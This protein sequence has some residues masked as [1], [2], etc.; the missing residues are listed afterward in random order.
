MRD[1]GIAI[2]QIGLIWFAATLSFQLK[3]LPA[4]LGMMLAGLGWLLM[5]RHEK[6]KLTPPLFLPII[7]YLLLLTGLPGVENTKKANQIIGMSVP[8][9]VFPLLFGFNQSQRLS[10]LLM[11][12][13]VYATAIS[14]IISLG[15]LAYMLLYGPVDFTY[16]HYSPFSQIPSHYIAMYFAFAGGIL[17]LN[18]PSSEFPNANALL[19]GFVLAVALL[20]NARIQFLVVAIILIWWVKVWVR[21]YPQKL[22][23]VLTIIVALVVLFF[24]FPEN[25]RRL[26]ETKDEFRNLANIDQSKQ[27]NHRFYLWEHAFEVISENPLMGVGTGDAN[28]KLR[29]AYQKSDAQFWD[30][31]GLY[32]LRDIGYNYHNQFLQSWAQN[33]L[34]AILALLAMFVML[35]RKRE[36]SASLLA[37]VLF[38]SM[39]TESLLERQ[40]GLF[41]VSFMYCLVMFLPKNDFNKVSD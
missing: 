30:G 2:L 16:R 32:Y 27:R 39:L 10:R 31:E 28:D 12:I 21:N 7:L 26:Q 15:Y 17:V 8:L 23:W 41:F 24:S 1:K 9:L 14:A 4:A 5:L 37:L 19:G 40:A 36:T 6:F 34:P 18:A 11:S 33:G 13:F 22:A 38:F 3:W 35:L 25:R 29:A 20:M